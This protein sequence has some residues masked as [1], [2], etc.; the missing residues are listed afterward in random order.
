VA[1]CREIRR[2]G[3]VPP[4]GAFYQLVNVPPSA[5]KQRAVLW[6]QVGDVGAVTGAAMI[7]PADQ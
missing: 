6:V 3:L 2:L 7:P 4:G 5:R 1:V